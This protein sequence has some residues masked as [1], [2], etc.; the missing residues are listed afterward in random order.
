MPFNNSEWCGEEIKFF[1]QAILQVT[2]VRK[3]ESGSAS[4]RKDDESGRAHSDLRHILNV[5]AR[6]AAFDRRGR[7]AATRL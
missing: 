4:F 2:L 5:E 7:A 6:E 1:A 3:M